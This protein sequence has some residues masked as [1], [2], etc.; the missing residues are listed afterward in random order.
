[1][2]DLEHKMCG[3]GINRSAESQSD[4]QD[5]QCCNNIN[6]RTVT[7]FIKSIVQQYCAVLK[8]THASLGP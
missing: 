8:N 5:H 3:L 7:N 6:L 2:C 4:C 1:M